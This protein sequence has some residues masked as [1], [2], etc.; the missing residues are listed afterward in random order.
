MTSCDRRMQ[1]TF[2]RSHRSSTP[3]RSGVHGL[4]FERLLSGG[5]RAAAPSKQRSTSCWRR[6]ADGRAARLAAAVVVFLGV[7]LGGRSG[8]VVG[9]GGGVRAGFGARFPPRGGRRRG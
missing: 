9:G 2:A 4:R 1:W 5:S 8:V 6:A 3:R 7:G